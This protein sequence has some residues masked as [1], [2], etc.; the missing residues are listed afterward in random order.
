MHKCGSGFIS[1]SSCN[2]NIFAVSTTLFII[3][4]KSFFENI[5]KIFFWYHFDKICF[6]FIRGYDIIKEIVVKR[7]CVCEAG[8]DCSAVALVQTAVS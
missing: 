3:S 6:V 5:E 7:G 4:Q 2:H 8:R 1:L